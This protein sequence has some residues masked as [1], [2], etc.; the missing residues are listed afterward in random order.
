MTIIKNIL[1]LSLLCVVV[2]CKMDFGEVKIEGLEDVKIINILDGVTA[3]ATLVVERT[4]KVITL[5]DSS[6]EVIS[7]ESGESLID[8]LILNDIIIED[9]ANRIPI[10]FKISTK[11]GIFEILPLITKLKDSEN[12]KDNFNFSVNTNVKYGLASKRFNFENISITELE[13]YLGNVIK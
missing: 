13:K 9:G 4:G 6:V 12:F 3:S 11:R 2:S 8:V 5:S 1:L 7:K 10:E